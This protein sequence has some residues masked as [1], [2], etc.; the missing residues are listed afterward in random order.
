[1]DI[2]RRLQMQ[3]RI[4]LMALRERQKREAHTR[5]WAIR[6]RQEE[7][8]RQRDE[9]ARRCWERTCPD[10]GQ[11]RLY[12]KQCCRLPASLPAIIRMIRLL[13]GIN[14]VHGVSVTPKEWR[15]WGS[16]KD[17]ARGCGPSSW[18]NTVRAL[19]EDR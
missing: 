18:D 11:Q 17:G 14:A 7:E 4:R 6:D 1:M 16:G 19:E 8:R 15:D 5:A 3:F 10:C 9:W 12:E 13:G 2:L